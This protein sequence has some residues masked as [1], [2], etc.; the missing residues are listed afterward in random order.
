MKKKALELQASFSAKIWAD[1]VKKHTGVLPDL[2]ERLAY[3][4]GWAE[5]KRPSTVQKDPEQPVKERV[6]EVLRA[7][8][9]DEPAPV[10]FLSDVCEREEPQVLVALKEL[11]DEGKIH[12]SRVSGENVYFMTEAVRRILEVLEKTA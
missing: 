11:Q 12:S 6:F 8:P 7:L 5:A 2:G 9:Y 1:R 4:I 10:W 3:A